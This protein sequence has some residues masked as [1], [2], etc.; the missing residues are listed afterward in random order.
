MTPEQMRDT[1]T[2]AG[3]DDFNVG[4]RADFINGARYTEQ[5]HG[6]GITAKA[7]GGAA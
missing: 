5:H 3:Y 4:R 1:L 6:I 2:E 7:E